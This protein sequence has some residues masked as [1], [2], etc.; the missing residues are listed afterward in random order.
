MCLIVWMGRKHS[1]HVDDADH[2]DC[3]SQF[4]RDAYH[5]VT[6]GLYSVAIFLLI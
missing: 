5:L 6:W 1:F 3:S 4:I 2:I